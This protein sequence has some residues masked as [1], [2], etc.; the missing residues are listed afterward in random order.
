MHDHQVCPMQES[1]VILGNYLFP[2]NPETH[3]RPKLH[4][5]GQSLIQVASKIMQIKKHCNKLV[6]AAQRNVTPV[7]EKRKVLRKDIVSTKLAIKPRNNFKIC[8]VLQK[9]NFTL[10]THKC[11]FHSTLSV[12]VES[13]PK[14]LSLKYFS[15]RSWKQ[16]VL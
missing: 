6:K 11:W 15:A 10:D 14:I 5:S 4:F 8:W 1:Q 2:W 16:D 12:C 13:F 7:G 3:Q 9:E